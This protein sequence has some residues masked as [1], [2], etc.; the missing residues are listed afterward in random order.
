MLAERADAW[1]VIVSTLILWLTSA[2]DG[3][4]SA[5]VAYCLGSAA[6]AELKVIGSSE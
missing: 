1:V 6:E 5:R 2:R 3:G 4:T